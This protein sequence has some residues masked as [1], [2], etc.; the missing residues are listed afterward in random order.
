MWKR[1]LLRRA[2]AARRATCDGDKVTMPY[3]ESQQP[4]S[5][6]AQHGKP[7]ALHSD[8]VDVFQQPL[9]KSAGGD[10]A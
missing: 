2:A 1:N 8:M 4:R 6:L 9:P 5:N 7:L 3:D 10:A